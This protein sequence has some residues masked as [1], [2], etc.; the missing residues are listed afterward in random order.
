[1]GD[2]MNR[3][4]RVIRVLTDNK[5]EKLLKNT[6]EKRKIIVSIFYPSDE[7]IK[8][9]QKGSYIN[10]FSPCEEEFIKKFARKKNMA[11]Q[12][13]DETYLKSIKT[14]TFNN[15]EISNREILYPVIIFSPGL[16][17]DRDCLIYNIEKL[18][19]EGFI[20]FTLGHIYETDFTILPS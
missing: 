9:N 1:M 19:S 6:G 5:R 17:M 15:I 10:L 14:N 8:E 7:G 18:V 16:G 4:G 13:V 11:G 2:I 3:V 20:V 12:Q